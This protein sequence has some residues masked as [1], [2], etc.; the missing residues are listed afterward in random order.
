MLNK[1]WIN[2]LDKKVTASLSYSDGK[3]I[4]S[5]YLGINFRNV[6]KHKC[7]ALLLCTWWTVTQ[8]FRLFFN[9]FHTIAQLTSNTQFC[10]LLPY[11]LPPSLLLTSPVLRSQTWVTTPIFLLRGCV[12]GV[13]LSLWH[14]L[15]VVGPSEG[16]LK[17]G[18][19]V[20]GSV[21]VKGLSDTKLS[22]CSLLHGGHEVSSLQDTDLPWHPAPLYITDQWANHPHMATSWLCANRSFPSVCWFFSVIIII[23]FFTPAMIKIMA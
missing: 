22:S 15:E 18:S 12:K 17:G 8:W 21:S 16:G 19:K 3:T 13:V 9:G 5:I 23:F 4:Q 20:T 1:T 6:K 11:R 2:Q 7:N 10:A 14:C